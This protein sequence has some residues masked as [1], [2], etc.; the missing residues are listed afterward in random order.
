MTDQSISTDRGVSTDTVNS[1]LLS[2]GPDIFQYLLTNLPYFGGPKD[3][4]DAHTS[5]DGDRD[6]LS[7]SFS[8][9][10]SAE[11]ICIVN[12]DSEEKYKLLALYAK[13]LK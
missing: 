2:P 11:S 3:F 10:K 4:G 1:S 9:T 13:Q 12:T 6:F 7:T 5:S 8:Q